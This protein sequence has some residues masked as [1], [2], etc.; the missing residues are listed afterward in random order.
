[1]ERTNRR[2]LII[3]TA[4]RLFLENG[5]TNTSVRQIAEAANMTEA[6]LYYH[7][8]EGKRELF[9]HAMNVIAPDFTRIID[10][11]Q[12]AKTLP[13]FVLR[14]GQA[15][16]PNLESSGARIRWIVTQIQVLNEDERRIII[17]R[18]EVFQELLAESLARFVPD[19]PKA[20]QLAWMLI[21]TSFG[22]GY[23][24]GALQVDSAVFKPQELID[25]LT[26]NLETYR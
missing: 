1:M 6:A 26:Q 23:L 8:K 17:N 16:I 9:Q 10:E 4:A 21:V 15:M 3:E 19:A 2:D 25:I 24:F 18:I 22:Y 11:C 5:Y 7:F 20:G 14:M 13:E 12:Q